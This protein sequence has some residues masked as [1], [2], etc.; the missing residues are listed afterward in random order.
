MFCGGTNICAIK[1]S[2]QLTDN[3]ALVYV[4]SDSVGETGTWATELINTFLSI[5]ENRPF[6]CILAEGASAWGLHRLFSALNLPVFA[7]VHNFGLVH[8][9]NIWKEVDNVRSL[10]YYLCK[11]VPRT[12]YRMI[13][14]DIPFLKNSRWVISG[15]KFNE[16]LLRRFYR[17]PK[18]RL[19][20][21]HNWIN[22]S[23]FTPALSLRQETREKLRIPQN[24]LTFLLVGSLWRP[25]GFH[26][27]IKSFNNFVFLFPNAQ[28]L[29]VGAGSYESYLRQLQT[30]NHCITNKVRFLG[31]VPNSELPAIYNSADIFLN[32]SLISEVL[33][34]VLVEAMSCGLPVIATGLSGN[35]E[36]VGHAGI[37]VPPGDIDS[38]TDAMLF[39]AK[40]PEKRKRF[41]NSAR[42][43][44]IEFFSEEIADRKI[45]L[46]FKE[47]SNL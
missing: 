1:A 40:D 20:V 28:L 39:L 7:F 14:Y 35:K 42:E 11:T 21:I 9:Y 37:L 24:D 5:H 13:F 2:R 36:A 29:I 25:K 43:R 31:P 41:G 3:L 15:S 23:Q 46:L 16:A 4:E 26:I 8:F 32:P 34:Y 18:S 6:D 22:S 38:L 44:V 17:I 12:F 33:P 45:S 10:L 27:A 30:S 47:T 19:R